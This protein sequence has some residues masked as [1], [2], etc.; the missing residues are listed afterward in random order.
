M[1]AMVGSAF[2]PVFR[3]VVQTYSATLVL[4]V[5][6]VLGG[7]ARVGFEEAVEERHII[8]A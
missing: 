6:V 3:Y 4:P 5:S 7:N 1:C 8:K 2:P